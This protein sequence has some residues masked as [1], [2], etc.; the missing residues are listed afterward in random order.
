V[1]VAYSGGRDSLDLLHATVRVAALLGL[2]VV[3][4]HVHHGLQAEADD[5][6]RRAQALCRRWQQAGKPVRL[7]WHRVHGSPGPG[8]SVE[9]WARRQRHAALVRMAR[10]AGAT[11]LL[12]AHH[13]RDQAETVLL[14]AL[15]GAGPRGL[16]AMPRVIEREG[17]TWARPWLMQPR[18]A[19]EAYVRRH[20]LRPVEDPSN[21]DARFARNRL[22]L[23]LWPALATSFA[24]AELALASAAVQAQ[25]AQAAL[26]ELAALD[27]ALVAD[28]QGLVHARWRALSPPRQ[29]NA[30]RAWLRQGLA[31]GAPHTL[32]ERL[33]AE[34]QPGSAGQW[35]AGEDHVVRAYRGRLSIMP[36]GRASALV[37][38]P[39]A[40]PA[41]PMDLSCPGDHDLPAWRG[42]LRLQPVSGGGLAIAALRAAELRTRA[43]GEQFQRAPR[44][45]P[46]SLKKQYQLAAVPAADRAGPLLWLDDQ[47][48]WVPGLGVD[49]RCR[50]PEGTAQ[51]LPH[52]LPDAP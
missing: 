20:R 16:S 22:R 8:D 45:P 2:Q 31:R 47:L 38:G 13:R 44:T 32:V 15:R 3:A 30:L 46:R 18:E 7:C 11:L 34:W 39:A 6:L 37:A 27:L 9:A 10:E 48:A 35:H 52:W 33:L 28:P 21:A 5:W 49:A 12:L 41:G 29:R 4:L 14:Q 17:L 25:Q 23:Q 42:S 26:D 43:G 1:A 51:L 50:A 36:S 24:D 40:A 19:I